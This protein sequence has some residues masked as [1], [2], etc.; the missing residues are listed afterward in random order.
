MQCPP[1][2]AWY[3][4]TFRFLNLLDPDYNQLSPVRIQA[5][6]ATAQMAGVA[7]SNFVT[8]HGDA[9]VSGVS[10]LYAGLAHVIHQT[11]KN[12]RAINAARGGPNANS[13]GT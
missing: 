3:V 11:D 10:F 4:K 12:N 5:W 6:L 9:L 2:T 13:P 8:Q 1:D 7:V